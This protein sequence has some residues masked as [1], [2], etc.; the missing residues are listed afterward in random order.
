MTAT[1]FVAIDPDPKHFG[2]TK[3]LKSAGTILSGMAV[4]F[5][6]TGIDL[7]VIPATTS[8]GTAIGIA[9][10]SANSGYEVTV[11]MEGCVCTAVMAADDSAID[12]GHWVMIG[13][14]AGTVIEW[15]PAIGVHAAT[16]DAGGTSVLG[17]AL[18]DSVVGAATVGSTVQILI[19]PVP[20]FTAS[21]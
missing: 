12:A 2:L 21:S 19:H 6:A 16:L 13:A 8:T 4:S 17:M 11:L 10:N 5:A 14:V 18:K 7:S 20:M 9:Q 15:D 3:T 1:T